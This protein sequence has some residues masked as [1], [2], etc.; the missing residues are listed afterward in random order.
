[1]WSDPLLHLAW[2]GHSL[3][4]HLGARCST[5]LRSDCTLDLFGELSPI[6]TCNLQYTSIPISASQYH[7]IQNHMILIRIHLWEVLSGRPFLRTLTN[8]RSLI[9][10]ASSHTAAVK[11][12]AAAPCILWWVRGALRLY[13]GYLACCAGLEGLQAQRTET[14]NAV[15]VKV[16]NTQNKLSYFL[17]NLMV[18]FTKWVVCSKV[19]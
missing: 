17:W 11:A 16:T 18:W 15:K 6:C 14:H 2:V 1:M 12:D 8:I 7:F 9:L 3:Y 19:C 10:S 4:R 13:G 5:Q